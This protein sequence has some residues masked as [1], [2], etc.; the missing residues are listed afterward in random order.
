MSHSFLFAMSQDL[1]NELSKPRPLLPCAFA[2]TLTYPALI[3]SQ[4]CCAGHD[5]DGT[6]CVHLAW[7]INDGRWHSLVRG[8]L[9][10]G[11]GR[12]A[13]C[14]NIAG[15]RCRAA[16]A[17]SLCDLRR[18]L[19]PQPHDGAPTQL[20]DPSRWAAWQLHDPE[21]DAGCVTVLRR[22]NATAASLSLGLRG[23][24]PST[25]Y[26]V[27][28][29]GVEGGEESFKIARSQVMDGSKLASLSVE[30]APSTSV[31]LRYVNVYR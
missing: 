28:W 22:P 19:D 25:E 20:A 15:C 10:L 11:L 5:Q 9:E 14:G 13:P 31:V 17:A 26:N 6:G 1:G 18:L 27:S 30:L 8:F 29:T 3:V 16:G 12:S 7:C 24:A 2:T 4:P 23:L 21:E